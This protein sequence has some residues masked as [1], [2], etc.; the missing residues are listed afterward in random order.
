[1]GVE[2]KKRGMPKLLAAIRGLTHNEALVGVPAENAGREPAPG[3]R[4]PALNNAEIGYIHEF[5]ATVDDGYGESF[6]IPP[7][8]HLRPAIAGARDDIARALGNGVRAA[9]RGEMDAAD[10]ALHAAGMIG[11]NAVRDRLT[12][13]PFQPLSPVTL[14]KRR[15]RRRTGEKPLID[16]GAYRNAQTYVVRKK[17]DD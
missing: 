2:I 13:G 5:G 14:A 10:K 11:Q 8:P 9:L 6:D 7:R 16:T 3:E 12:E 15:A 17:G 1:M 4:R